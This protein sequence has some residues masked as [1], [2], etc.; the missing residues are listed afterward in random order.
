MS[1]TPN[2]TNFSTFLHAG[3]QDFWQHV[4]LLSM[5]LTVYVKHEGLGKQY[6]ANESVTRETGNQDFGLALI[7]DTTL[8]LGYWINNLCLEAVSTVF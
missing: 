7:N 2:Y 6:I 3:L 5:S 1:P 4:V 8:L